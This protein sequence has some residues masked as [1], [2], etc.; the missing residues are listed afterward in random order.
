MLHEE[1]LENIRSIVQRSEKKCAP[2]RPNAALKA[3]RHLRGHSLDFTSAHESTGFHVQTRRSLDVPK[4]ALSRDIVPYSEP[5]EGA[6]IAR[7]FENVV[8]ATSSLCSCTLM[9]I[10]TIDGSILCLRRIRSEL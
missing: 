5:E 6:E 7:I 1:I 4:R 8:I 3:S 10:R 9:L 2:P